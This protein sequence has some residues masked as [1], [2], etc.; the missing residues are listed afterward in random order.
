MPVLLSPEVFIIVRNQKLK[1]D[2]SGTDLVQFKMLCPIYKVWVCW[3]VCLFVCC[4][5]NPSRCGPMA[6]AALRT[7]AVKAGQGRRVSMKIS[8]A[9]VAS[10][11]FC[12]KRSPRVNQLMV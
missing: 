3:F 8:D 7:G 4:W 10:K 6:S 2:M 5:F 12:Q 1:N 11:A 9:P